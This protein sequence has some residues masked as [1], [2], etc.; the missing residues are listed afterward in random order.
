[1][2]DGERPEH[3]RPIVDEDEDVDWIVAALTDDDPKPVARTGARSS[4]PAIDVGLS[5]TG[6][7]VGVSFS[8]GGGANKKKKSKRRKKLIEAATSTVAPEK[9]V[10][11]GPRASDRDGGGGVLGRI[12][13]FSA[14][15]LVSRSL[16]GAYPGDALP[17]TE[18]ASATGLSE[19]AVKYGYGDWSDEEEEYSAPSAKRHRQKRRKTTTSSNSSKRRRKPK[20]GSSSSSLSLDFD[21]APP[22]PKTSPRAEMLPRRDSSKSDLKSRRSDKMVRLPTERLREKDAMLSKMEE[23]LSQLDAASRRSRKLVRAP[24]ELLREKDAALHKEPK[25]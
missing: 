24:T 5:T 17:P 14:N 3:D 2:D 15:N 8:I 6:V 7:T 11:A 4:K 25:G 23:E 10:K 21:F 22:F 13:D 19:F 9:R 18:A 20:S 16:L 12:R 1:M